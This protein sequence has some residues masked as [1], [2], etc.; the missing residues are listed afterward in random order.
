MGDYGPVRSYRQLYSLVIMGP[1]AFVDNFH[2]VQ[3]W[4]HSILSA[5]LLVG[6]SVNYDYFTDWV[7]VG[8]PELSDKL[9]LRFY[10]SFRQCCASLCGFERAASAFWRNASSIAASSEAEASFLVMFLAPLP[11]PETLDF[12]F[13]ALLFAATLSSWSDS[14][15]IPP[16]RTMATTFDIFSLAPPLVVILRAVLVLVSDMLGIAG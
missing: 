15:A 2:H 6:P 13:F 11:T 8:F 9:S 7:H 12:D 16:E 10:R 1:L 5:T 14:S 3:Q 4:A